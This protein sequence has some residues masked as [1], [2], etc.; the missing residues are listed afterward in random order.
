MF[1]AVPAH[2]TFGV[3]MGYFLG[4]AKFEHQKSH[5]AIYAL[6]VATLFHGAYDYF[7]FISYVPGIWLGAIASLF[8]GIYLSRRAI[9]IH[10]QASPFIAK[11]IIEEV[12]KNELNT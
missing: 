3:L 1:T 12:D 6:G 11:P 7:W 5:Y 9:L 10:Q 8:I 2:A 4:K